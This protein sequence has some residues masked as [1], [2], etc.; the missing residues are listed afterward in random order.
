MCV[1]VCV[2]VCVC[3]SVCVCVCVFVCLSV[4]LCVCDS[5]GR[6]SGRA[7]GDIDHH[8]PYAFSL[9]STRLTQCRQ[10]R[11][12]IGSRVNLP[13]PNW[14][15]ARW[16]SVPLR[17]GPAINLYNSFVVYLSVNIIKPYLGG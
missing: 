16:Q 11:S 13:P 1:C 4:C 2:C 8:E 7:M 15:E 10:R 6:I 3:M 14:T 12:F 17:F 5:L 9:G